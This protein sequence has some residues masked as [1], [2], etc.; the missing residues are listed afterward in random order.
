ML[1]RKSKVKFSIK[2][3]MCRSGE[4]AYGRW[5]Y[6]FMPHEVHPSLYTAPLLFACVDGHQ[7]A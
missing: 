3:L 7:R 1:R 2:Q 4:M 6:D 5:L